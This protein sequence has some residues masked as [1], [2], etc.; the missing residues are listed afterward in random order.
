MTLKL[1]TLAVGG[2]LMAAT[3]LTAPA[4]FAQSVGNAPVSSTIQMIQTQPSLNLSA[5]GEVKVAPDMATITFGVVT[6]AATA[7][8]AM[9]QN[10]TQ[11][12][13]VAAA[14]RRAGIA[15][16]DIQTSGLNLQAQY[17]Y[18]QNEPPRLRGYQATNRVTVN[19]NDLTKVGT[20]ADAVVAAGVNQI[21]GISFGLKDPKTAE[22]Q[23]RRLAVQA[24]QAKARLYAEALGVQLGGIRSLNEGGGYA[25]QPP[26][27]VFAMARMQSAG[28][29]STPVSAGELSVK[30]DITGVY[31]IR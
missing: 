20:T 22:D 3:A 29:D 5:T 18:V 2:A 10:A 4:A 19:I 28:A 24:L 15:E 12:T 27:P 23:A 13:R 21:D 7:Q 1:R 11:M 30:I 9:A 26:M 14:L 16:R 31:D 25:P 17:D 6:E 8:E